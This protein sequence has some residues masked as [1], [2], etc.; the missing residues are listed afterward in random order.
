MNVELVIST[1]QPFPSGAWVVSAIYGGC[2]VSRTYLGYT[3][4]EAVREFRRDIVEA[5][6]SL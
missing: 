5:V 3:K 6:G 1:Y 4:R 2:L